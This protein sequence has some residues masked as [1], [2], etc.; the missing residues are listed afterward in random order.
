MN[1]RTNCEDE[2]ESAWIVGIG[3]ETGHK[4][5]INTGMDDDKTMQF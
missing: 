5:A 1:G 4:E 2:T 3:W